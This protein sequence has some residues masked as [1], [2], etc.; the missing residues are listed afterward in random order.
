[1]LSKKMV[2]AKW[3]VLSIVVIFVPVIRS[4]GNVSYGFPT[5]AIEAKS[6]FEIE[7]VSV[8]NIILNIAVVCSLI[9]CI[10][11]VY[12]R[13]INDSLILR[14]GFRFV[15]IYHV[16]I[17]FGFCAIYWLGLSENDLFGY[18]AGAYSILIY[19]PFLFFIELHILENVSENSI[20]FGD[21]L[22]IQMRIVYVLMCFVWFLLGLA[23][24]KMQHSN[25]T[26]LKR[27]IGMR[28]ENEEN[29]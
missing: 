14:E 9:L 10:H 21:S 13:K 8:P 22:D 12:T 11:F 29:T 15:Y 7:H 3:I 4:C 24:W 5:V 18:I 26:H 16:L 2:L 20:F 28:N 19:G 25:K 27:D 1:M 17:L 23:K 6:P